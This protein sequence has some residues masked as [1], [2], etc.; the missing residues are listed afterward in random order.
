M[1]ITPVTK[2]VPD[3]DN[4]GQEIPGTVMRIVEVEEPFSHARLEDGTF[5][6]ARLAFTEIVRLN[7]RVDEKGKP[8]VSS[9]AN[10]V[11]SYLSSRHG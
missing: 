1:P 10:R 11:F 9:D 7:D 4:P 5:I 6:T 2:M 8:Q 3:P